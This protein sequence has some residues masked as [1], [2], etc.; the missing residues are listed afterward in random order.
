MNKKYLKYIVLF[1]YYFIC[2]TTIY[3]VFRMDTYNNYGFSYGIVTGGTPYVDFNPIVPLFGPF[4][5][6][7]LLIFN[8]S[9][10]VFYLE[11]TILLLIMT[12]LLFKLLDNRAWIIIVLLFLPIV[13]PF[14]YC[15]FP[16][17]NFLLLF[18]LIIL[19]YLNKYNKDDKLIGL[20]A[21]ITIITKHNIGV[22]IFLITLLAVFKDKKKLLNRFLFGIISG[23]IFLLVLLLYG[24][25]LEF[26]DLCLLGA[27]DFINNI[28]VYPFYL[29]I[30]LL[31]IIIMIIKYIKDNNKNISYYYLLV[32]LM[33]VFPL[34]DQYHV[35]LFLLF[36]LIVFLY[37]SKF[38]FDYKTIPIIS[39]V[40]IN[41]LILGW[42]LINYDTYNR[43]RIYNYDNNEIILLKKQEKKNIDKLNKYLK[44]KKYT[45]LGNPTNSIFLL[46]SNNKKMDMFIVLF[47]GNYG[48]EGINNVYKEIDKRKDFYIVVDTLV[49]CEGK[50]GCQ[51]LEEVPNY[52]VN[53][54]KLVKEIG[55]YKIYYKK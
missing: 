10:I 3:F 33:V 22:F 40:I 42:S 19:L 30:L 37:N 34:A 55:H 7:I 23:I 46:T 52:V 53:N 48:K 14:A 27:S 50:K 8:H 1:I 41:V 54:Y 45:L 11:Q 16:G 28:E 20:V 6:S 51:Y 21:G 29:I 38:S 32:Y 5:Y 36:Y 24:N 13:V 35:S 44:D 31:S 18:E 49:N 17:Y 39:F 4:L 9:I 47:R 15:L 26:I 2:L 43:F 12:Y 25:I